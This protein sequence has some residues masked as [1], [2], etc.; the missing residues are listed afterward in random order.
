MSDDYVVGDTIYVDMGFPD[1]EAMRVKAQLAMRI[2]D[3][4]KA[5]GLIPAKAAELIGMTQPELSGML[6]GQ[7][8]GVSEAKMMD[9]LTALGKDIE[10]VVR[11]APL[12]ETGHVRVTTETSS[13]AV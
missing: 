2:A 10:I 3:A 5:K 13:S 8:R 1:A 6:Q 7:F 11:P 4:I 9:C 12:G